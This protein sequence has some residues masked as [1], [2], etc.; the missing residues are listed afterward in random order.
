MNAFNTLLNP[1]LLVRVLDVS[2][3]D[4]DGAAVGFLQDGDDLADGRRFQ[5]E[6]VVDEDL[7]VHVLFRKPIGL[8]IELWMLGWLL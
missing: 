8:R 2:E 6:H 7:P 4:T 3:F 1:R 5:A